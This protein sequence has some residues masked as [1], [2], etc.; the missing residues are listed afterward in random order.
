[1]SQDNIDLVT[2]LQPPPEVDIAQLFRRDEMWSALV[3]AVAQ[4]FHVDF[5]SVAPGVPGTEKT[6]VGLEGLRAAWLEWIEPWATYRTEIERA[7][8]CGERVLLLTQDYGR[9]A[10]ASREVKVDG[11]A[12]WT[13]VDGR[14]A[15]AEFFPARSEAFKAAGL[16]A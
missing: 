9:Q 11:S 15:R 5:V 8:D 4:F 13:V 10:G 6:H 14:I 2:K 12:V 1:M 16:A 7:I 3:E